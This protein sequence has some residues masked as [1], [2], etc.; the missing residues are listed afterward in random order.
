V[1]NRSNVHV[2]LVAYEFLFR[3]DGLSGNSFALG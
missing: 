1:T 3:H 2:R